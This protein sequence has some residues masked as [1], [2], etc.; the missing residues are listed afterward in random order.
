MDAYHPPRHVEWSRGIR[1]SS[2]FELKLFF[3]YKASAYESIDASV[4][5]KAWE[6]PRA[7]EFF[8]SPARTK[9]RAGGG[10]HVPVV[11]LAC[12]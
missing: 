10:A 1:V 11:P 12:Q 8:F 2:H 3:L 9:Q 6:R 4:D 5:G 7:D